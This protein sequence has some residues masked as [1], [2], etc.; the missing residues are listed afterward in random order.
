MRSYTDKLEEKSNALTRQA[1]NLSIKVEDTRNEYQHQVLLN[2]NQ[3]N[4]DIKQNIRLCI[5]TRV[6]ARREIHAEELTTQSNEIVNSLESIKFE[7]LENEILDS[8]NV[9]KTKQM[10]KLKEKEID[11]LIKKAYQ[12]DDLIKKIFE[13]KRTEN[14]KLSFKLLKKEVKLVMRNLQ[15]RNDRIYFKIRLLIFQSNKLKLHLL[16]KHHDI[17]MQRYSDYK[18]MHVKLLKNYY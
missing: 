6:E 5:I 13:S 10:K 11:R 8:D 12:N 16:K 2:E 1:Q 7:S 18:V 9:E 3:L 4:D 15:I 14:R 17:L